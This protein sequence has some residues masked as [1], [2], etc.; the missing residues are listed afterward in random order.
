MF[1][2]TTSFIHLPYRVDGSLA[3]IEV[4]A[5]GSKKSDM[6]MTDMA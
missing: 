4:K 1:V 6:E 2:L 3:E 5:P